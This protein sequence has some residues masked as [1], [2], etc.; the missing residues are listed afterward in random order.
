MNIIFITHPHFINSTSMPLY[1]KWLKDGMEARGHTTEVWT[2]SSY[3]TKYI[4]HPS[5]KKWLGYFDQYI[6]FPFN[7]KKRLKNISKDTLFVFTDQALGPWVPYF[8]DRKHIIHCHDFLA[9]KSAIGEV[10][11]N[12]TSLT[13]K[14]YQKYIRNGYLRGNNFICISKQTQNDL[15]NFFKPRTPLLSR[16]VY[17]GLNNEFKPL[18]KN[19][20][21][22]FISDL[23]NISLPEGFILH[24]GGN[25][26]YKNRLGVLEIYNEW[27]K[28][29]KSSNIPLIM[30]GRVPNEQLINF[31]NKSIFKDSIFFLSDVDFKTLKMA[32]CGSR[33]FIFPSLAEGFGWPIAEAMASGVPVITTDKMPMS[34]VGGKA[35]FYLVRKEINNGEIFIN[36]GVNTLDKILKLSDKELSE[37]IEEGFKQSNKFDSNTA[38]NQIEGIYKEIV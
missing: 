30:V 26:W 37:V 7:I 25:Q 38:L 29:N 3:L 4:N 14:I 35:A 23:I 16:V 24:V 8:S 15:F 17:N 12:P 10:K 22:S 28:Q 2:A 9:Q 1:A 31:K 21:R 5:L 13:G 6:I 27:R 33:V 32:Y 11:E 36:Q 19:Y 18:D 20:C 34:E